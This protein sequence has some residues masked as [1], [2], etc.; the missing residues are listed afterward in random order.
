LEHYLEGDERRYGLDHRGEA[1]P[2]EYTCAHLVGLDGRRFLDRPLSE[3][4][5]N[6]LDRFDSPDGDVVGIVAHEKGRLFVEDDDRV[7]IFE[8]FRWFR[9]G[10]GI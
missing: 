7:E 1:V 6:V 10:S 5:R 4:V 8:M 9:L 2:F 3:A